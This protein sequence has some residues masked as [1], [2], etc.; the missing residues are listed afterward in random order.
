[1]IIKLLKVNNISKYSKFYVYLIIAF[2][3]GALAN[4]FTNQLFISKHFILKSFI[5]KRF[6]SELSQK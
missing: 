1:M 2:L 3:I 6:T 5:C 4:L